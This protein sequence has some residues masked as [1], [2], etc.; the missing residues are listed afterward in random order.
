MKRTPFV[1]VGHN[2]VV[3]TALVTHAWETLGISPSVFYAWIEINY[4]VGSVARN[5]LVLRAYDNEYGT[6]HSLFAPSVDLP[7]YLWDDPKRAE[8]SQASSR[9]EPI[10]PYRSSG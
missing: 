4:P 10:K 7:D 5:I 6:D 2:A 1:W 9:V 8:A 3:D